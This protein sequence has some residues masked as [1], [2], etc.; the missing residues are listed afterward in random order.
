MIVIEEAK[1]PSITDR[2]AASSA[3]VGRPEA[4]SCNS[5]EIDTVSFVVGVIDG[6]DEGANAGHESSGGV[7]MVDGDREGAAVNTVTLT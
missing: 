7:G 3:A 6:T 1:L 5:T 4:V 2:I